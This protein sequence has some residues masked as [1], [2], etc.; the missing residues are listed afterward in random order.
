MCAT[1]PASLAILAKDVFAA[2]HPHFKNFR[3]KRLLIWGGF[4]LA[5]G[6]TELFLLKKGTIDGLTYRK[7]LSSFYLPWMEKVF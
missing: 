5:Y 7:V 6:A 1:P 4:S 3:E 2:Q